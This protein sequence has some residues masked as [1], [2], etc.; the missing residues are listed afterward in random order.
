MK[1]TVQ[2]DEQALSPRP[3]GRL[4]RAR[5]AETVPETGTPSVSAHKAAKLS[6]TLK[7]RA[8]HPLPVLLALFTALVLMHSLT[9]P[10]FEAPDEV[11]H[12]AYVR[13]IAEERGL[14][15][16]DSDVSGANQQ[17]AQPPLYYGVA[18][19]LRAPFP[20]DDLDDLWWGNP[21]FGYQAPGTRADNK[22]MLIHT[23]REA[24]PWRGAVL[25]VRVTRLTSLLFGLATVIAAWGL[26]YEALGDRRGALTVAALVALHPQFIFICGVVSNDSAAAA[27]ATASLWIAARALRRGLTDVQAILAG[28][29]VGLAL[30]TKTSVLPLPVL[31]GAALLWA[32]WRARPQ[33][34]PTARMMGLYGKIT[35]LVG[36]WWY[37]RN[38]VLY[39]D[40]L[41]ISHHI[42]TPWGRPA[43]ATLAQ[44]LRELPL[45]LRSFW[46][47]Y[48]WGHIFWPEAVYVAL[49]SLSL[50]ALGLAAARALREVRTERAATPRLSALL[51]A[52]TWCG[53]IV[54]ALGVWMRQVGAPHGRLL[55]PALG[56]WA[57]LH[58][59]GLRDRPT[60]RQAL[61]GAMV[62]TAAL[63][64]GARLWAS[65]APPRLRALESLPRHVI[66][67]DLRAGPAQLLGVAVDRERVA[68]GETIAV[69]AC[70]AAT[71]P[72][73]EDYTVFV[74]LIGPENS[75]VAQRHT[76]PGLG[77]FPT[78]LW[79]VG[80]A[81][82]ETYHVRVERWAPGPTRYWLEVGLF[83]AEA[84]AR[85]PTRNAEGHSVEPP[86]VGAVVVTPRQPASVPAHPL[87]T[88]LADDAI[89]LR[90]VDAPREAAPGA[91]VAVT[92]T[93]EALSPPGGDYVAFVHL[94][95]PGDPAPLAQHDSPP[96]EGWFP[97]HLWRAGDVVVDAHPLPLP[98]TLEPG[99]YPLWAGL[100][101]ADDGT[102]ATARG[103]EGAYPFDLV[104]L[105]TLE[106]HAPPD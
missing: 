105:G 55:F 86:I 5:L 101:R 61:L 8:L 64:P 44:L 100:Y 13:W 104:P 76:Y 15:P 3:R 62:M 21:H 35:A 6:V 45:L 103:P 89:A 67:V 60:L 97:T 34:W 81:F 87:E 56:A 68:A 12:Y 40:P 73:D 52:L 96:R 38:L 10:L 63:A 78:S 30:L 99:E 82:C 22:N 9:T 7:S 24:W 106:V 39:G 70:W 88:T 37:T 71:A 92:L 42:A 51:L 58:A 43:P 95:R 47:A 23:T 33:L 36:G 1:V 16:M 32:A 83:E 48:G 11:W 29:L 72:I 14:P 69:T 20:D 84:G 77:R 50:G 79:P 28:V 94:W 74:H 80:R 93:W 26:G 90:G 25:A 91:T 4:N 17:V 59:Y 66:P 2:S 75:R 53:G 46:G 41:G 49:W 65:F 18:A 27:L 85:V 102:R 31:V 19:L 57:L 54:V 98:A